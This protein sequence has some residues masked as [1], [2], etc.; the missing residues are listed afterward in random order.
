M[1]YLRSDDAREFNSIDCQ[2]FY[3]THKIKHEMTTAG[4]PQL[5]GVA[6]AN[7]RTV[8]AMGRKIRLHSGLDPTFGYFAAQAALQIYNN[9]PTRGLPSGIT[10]HEAWTGHRS[11]LSDFR[12]FGC[13]C[14]SHLNKTGLSKMQARA[15]EGIYLGKAPNSK[16]SPNIYS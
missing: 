4:S 3:A 14:W 12:V 5:N 9:T 6:E 8:M 16:G 1:V 15:R 13:R 2:K 7:L 11:D 10:P